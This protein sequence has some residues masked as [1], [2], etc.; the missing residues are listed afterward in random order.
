MRRDST[1]GSPRVTEHRRHLLG[2][3]ATF[4][5][6]P[7]ASRSLPRRPPSRSARR[8]ARSRA[9][10]AAPLP[11]AAR[12]SRSGPNGAPR[13]RRRGRRAA[14]SSASR[15]RGT[16][17]PLPEV[18]HGRPNRAAGGTEPAGVSRRVARCPQPRP[19]DGRR[20]PGPAP[21]LPP[22]APRPRAQRPDPAV[23]SPPSLS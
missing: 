4:P 11:A 3:T 2:T 22:D 14:G 17:I 21:L 23:P 20:A 18:G 1:A 6:R 8:S 12:G 13:A 15:G 10:A 19:A 16:S 5:Q 7:R 9:H